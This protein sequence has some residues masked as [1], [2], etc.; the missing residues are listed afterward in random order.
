[1]PALPLKSSTKMRDIKEEQRRF[2]NKPNI[3][4]ATGFETTDA[5]AGDPEHTPGWE[6]QPSDCGVTDGNVLGTQGYERRL[7]YKKKMV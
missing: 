4:S 5:R 3:R 7:F 2:N 1:M 6:Q